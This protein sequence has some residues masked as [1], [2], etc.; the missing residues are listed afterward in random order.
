[1]HRCRMRLEA[2]RA[3]EARVVHEVH[4]GSTVQ[5]Q[6]IESAFPGSELETVQSFR[7]ND[8]SL[9]NTLYA[10]LYCAI[11]I[12][13]LF[14]KGAERYA[15]K[16]VMMVQCDNLDVEKTRNMLKNGTSSREL[17]RENSTQILEK[18]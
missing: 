2:P 16:I 6:F 15:R 5:Q 3:C 9:S 14:R 4:V 7:P 13:E 8:I 11:L 1:M 10:V 17:V 18:E 12:T